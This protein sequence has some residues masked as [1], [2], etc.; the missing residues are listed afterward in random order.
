[1]RVYLRRFTVGNIISLHIRPVLPWRRC[2]AGGFSQ[3][4]AGA[5]GGIERAAS[6]NK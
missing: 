2:D 3:A 6:A 5:S 1:M 4:E